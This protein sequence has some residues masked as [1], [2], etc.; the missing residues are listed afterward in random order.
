VLPCLDV[1]VRGG[2][3][4]VGS[5]GRGGGGGGR[6]R[7]RRVPRDAPSSPAAAALRLHLDVALQVEF[8]RQ[9]LKPFFFHLIG[10]KLWV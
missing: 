9:T 7:R 8:E 10:Y 2:A 1:V 5:D 3:D 6:E 4:D